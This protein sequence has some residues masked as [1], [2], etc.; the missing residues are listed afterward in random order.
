[1]AALGYPYT[2]MIIGP[3][4]SGKTYLLRNLVR[5]MLETPNAT[6]PR[7]EGV[8]G[9][10]LKP[11]R[12]IYLGQFTPPATKAT[13]GET[14]ASADAGHNNLI[15][16]ILAMGSKKGAQNKGYA[17]KD[18][19]NDEAAGVKK[20]ELQDVI[21]ALSGEAGGSKL[22]GGARQRFKRIM[23]MLEEE[24]KAGDIL[25]WDDLQ[26]FFP[27]MSPQE[28]TDFINLVIANC[29]HKGINLIYIFQSLPSAKV[30]GVNFLENL[31]INSH[32]V[33]VI[34]RNEFSEREFDKLVAF[35]SAGPKKM[36][37][38]AQALINGSP[39]DKKP[40][41]L[42][43][44]KKSIHHPADLH[45]AYHV[46]LPTTTSSGRNNSGIS[47]G[48]SGLHNRTGGTNG[49]GN[50]GGASTN[51]G[52]SRADA[53]SFSEKIIEDYE[54]KK[55]ST[56]GREAASGANGSK[57]TRSGSVEKPST[58]RSDAKKQKYN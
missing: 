7:Y 6:I 44:D 49:A 50:N 16:E 42:L 1:M 29:H 47:T 30:S 25:I 23:K 48:D 20:N 53:K 10:E 43:F 54:R 38:R 34:V 56:S 36:R 52:K 12:V 31:L 19:D 4:S 9:K 28:K 14:N 2:A 17:F 41:Y 8:P 46:F 55:Q 58:F 33:F 32:Y 39:P 35:T 57:K 15:R 13:G 45:E 11:S 18:F 21:S 40:H 3:S 37:E 27:L 22:A 24:L 5:A 26:C 51:G